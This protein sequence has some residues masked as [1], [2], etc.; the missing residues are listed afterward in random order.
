MSLIFLRHEG[1]PRCIKEGRD[2]SRNN[3]GVYVDH[4]WCFSC[5]YWEPVNGPINLDEVRA[6]L[7]K[8]R[9]SE[10]GSSVRL[11]SDFTPALPKE[12]L[13][14]L[15]K[16]AIDAEEIKLYRMGWSASWGRLIYPQYD[17]YGN[18]FFWQ[19]RYFKINEESPI[20]SKYFNQ[21]K[22]EMVDVILG[23]DNKNPQD[24]LFV[25]EDF[26]SAIKIARVRP[27]LCLWGS[28]MS[29]KRARRLSYAYKNLALWLDPD[30]AHHQARCQIKCR[31]Y[32]DR[33]STVNTQQDPKDHTMA[34]IH[35][36]V[37][38]V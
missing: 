21:G 2:H 17:K 30:K 26:V 37:Y 4:K 10:S 20:G 38:S 34:A 8:D 28:E 31:P 33:V 5:G 7:K 25:V 9:E 35:N 14:W 36:W 18:C 24:T 11:P 15:S 1:C 16:Y 23:K 32:F 29:V 19:G 27:T 6:R 13:E 22:P 12:P 3:L